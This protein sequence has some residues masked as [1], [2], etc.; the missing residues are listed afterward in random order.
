MKPLRVLFAALGC[1]FVVVG[2]VGIFVPLLPTTPFLLLAS[3][4]FARSSARLHNWLRTHRTFGRLL[5]DWEDGKGIPLRAKILAIA[6]MWPSMIYSMFRVGHPALKVML[7][8]IA[9]GVTIYL[10]RLPTSRR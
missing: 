2:I 8:V 1:F 6:M 4:C 7:F 10:W 9:C 3:A 5:R